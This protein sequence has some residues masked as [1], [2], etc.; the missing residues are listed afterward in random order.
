MEEGV[1]AWQLSAQNWILEVLHVCCLGHSLT[2]SLLLQK[3]YS[4]KDD[5]RV[6]N[7]MKMTLVRSNSDNERFQNSD[8]ETL[9][10]WVRIFVDT[11]IIFEEL[12]YIV[13]L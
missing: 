1:V 5:V 6:Q 11:K 12:F 13:N 8:L 3:M 7:I 9:K 2:S 4:M 10:Y